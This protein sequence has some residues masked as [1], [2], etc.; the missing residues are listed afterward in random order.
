MAIDIADNR[1]LDASVVLAALRGEGSD[2]QIPRLLNGAIV[3]TVNFAEVLTRAAEDLGA[4][5]YTADRVWAGLQV[6]CR[7]HLIR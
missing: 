5:V 2:D 1:V 6:G 7:I 3:S 4:E